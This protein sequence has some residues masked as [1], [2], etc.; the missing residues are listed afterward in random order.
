MDDYQWTSAFPLHIW[1][2]YWYQAASPPSRPGHNYEQW[3][4]IFHNTLQ[5]RSHLW[6]SKFDG[7]YALS[8]PATRNPW[9]HY[10][11]HWSSVNMTIVAS[12]GILTG[13]ATSNHLKF[14]NTHFSRN[15][16]ECFT[17]QLNDL[18][19]NVMQSPAS[20]R[21]KLSNCRHVYLN[22]LCTKLM[23]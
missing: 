10:G 1:N 14:F 21:L 12:Y 4:G 23:K 9:R 15:Y 20:A 5:K 18:K 17:N 7:S 22:V 6:G 2:W 19:R 8:K 11:N 16:M 3:C 13:L